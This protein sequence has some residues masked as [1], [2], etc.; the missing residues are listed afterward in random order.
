M[1]KK[2]ALRALVVLGTL[3]MMASCASV[4]TMTREGA[5]VPDAAADKFIIM[6]ADIHGMPGDATENAA[7]LFGGFVGAFKESGV[8]LQPIKPALEA[9]GMGNLSW[10]MAHGMY[11]V[12]SV[13][14][15]FDLK[16]DSTYHGDSKLAAYA[17]MTAKLVKLAA[18]KLSLDFDPTY[19]TCVHIDKQ[20][21]GM[22]GMMKYRVIGAI[23][24]VKAGMIDKVI[25]YE[26]NTGSDP[27]VVL[28]EMA[29]IGPKLH[30]L[31]FPP[32][33]EE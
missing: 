13:H 22:G 6:P 23:Y 20:G 16:K 14:N 5:P 2:R 21:G 32:A 29:S 27:K 3:A 10:E 24:N 11:H 25:W 30:A 4:T 7:A 15:T 18:E 12:V 19:V 17:E 33:E 9:A 31:L 28:A 1:L 26:Q 8:P